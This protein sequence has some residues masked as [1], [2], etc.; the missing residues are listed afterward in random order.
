MSARETHKRL[1]ASLKPTR[2]DAR[3]RYLLHENPTLW[4]SGANTATLRLRLGSRRI[5]FD[6]PIQIPF[7]WDKFY[8][9]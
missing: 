4:S 8:V 3:S 5:A 6:V 2:K 9:D 7:E 1:T